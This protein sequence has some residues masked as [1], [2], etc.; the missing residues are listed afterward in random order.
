MSKALLT[1]KGISSF[2]AIFLWFVGIVWCCREK[3]PAGRGRQTV[4]RQHSTLKQWT[5][6]QGKRRQKS[7]KRKSVIKTT[8]KSNSMNNSINSVWLTFLL[9]LKSKKRERRCK[10]SE[11]DEARTR[12]RKLQGS[13]RTKEAG[14]EWRSQED[15]HEQWWWRRRRG[16]KALER[17]S[18]CLEEGTKRCISMNIS[19][20]S[21]FLPSVVNYDYK[22]FFVKNKKY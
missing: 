9:S 2:V 14:R 17:K 13:K 18:L 6:S 16:K 4:Q 7:Y 21:S 15:E 1:F 8:K 3:E 22:D 20:R 11:E 19:I 12:R 5:G 10:L